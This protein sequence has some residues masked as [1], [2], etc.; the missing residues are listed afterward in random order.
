MFGD[1]VVLRVETEHG[2]PREV[3]VAHV[4]RC[5]EKTGRGNVY[6]SRK[7]ARVVALRVRA[8]T[9]NP[10]IHFRCLVCPY[11][12]IGKRREGAA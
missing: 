5:L 11:W 1:G 3:A 4:R 2:L 8:D 7:R 9:G 10:V 6:G 12:H